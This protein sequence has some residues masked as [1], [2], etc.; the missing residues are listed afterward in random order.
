MGIYRK[1][2]KYYGV[3]R[4]GRNKEK[5]AEGNFTCYFEGDSGLPASVKCECKE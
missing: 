2:K 1:G 3:V 4:L 5:P